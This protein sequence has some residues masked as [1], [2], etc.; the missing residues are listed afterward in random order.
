MTREQV[1]I[2][3]RISGKIQ[4]QHP[5][6][7]TRNLWYRCYRDYRTKFPNIPPTLWQKLFDGMTDSL[8]ARFQRETASEKQH[9]QVL[10]VKADP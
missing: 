7:A 3:V 4:Y 9:S 1:F 2:P 6:M 5:I 10:E 8:E